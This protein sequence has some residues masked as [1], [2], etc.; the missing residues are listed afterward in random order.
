MRRRFTPRLVGG[1]AIGAAALLGP[2][3]AP[4]A[5]AQAAPRRGGV[6]RMGIA[7]GNTSDTLDPGV[8][9]HVFTQVF[10]QARHAYMTEIAADGSL[11]GELAESWEVTPDAITWTFKL[12]PG[13]PYHDGRTVTADDVI[14]FAAERLANFK[15]P[16]RVEFV[17]V[18]P[19]N[20]GGKILK[21][22]LRE[23]A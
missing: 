16:R 7:H 9:E 13:V 2:M 3:G 10:N 21:T 19:R 17:D 11:V 18:L 15:V 12:R 8:A 22:E 1:A 20:L 6:F 14:A 5:M 23:R 4:L